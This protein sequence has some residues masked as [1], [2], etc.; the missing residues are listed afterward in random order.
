MY[1][2][3]GIQTWNLFSELSWRPRRIE[4]ILPDSGSGRGQERRNP[5]IFAQFKTPKGKSAKKVLLVENKEK[6]SEVGY[7]EDR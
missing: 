7:P 5:D 4:P 2:T 6:F 3:K 1:I